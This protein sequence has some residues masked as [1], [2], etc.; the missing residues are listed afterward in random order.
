MAYTP[1]DNPYIPGDPYSYD[2]KWI[3]AKIKEAL[4]SIEGL[5]TGQSNLSNDFEALREY[6]YDYFD[7]LNISQEVEDKINE[8]YAA[9]FFDDIIEEWMNG[10]I[11]WTNPNLLD[12]PWFT[13][14][15]RGF[16]TGRAANQY[17]ADR[18]FSDANGTYTNSDSN[19]T[20][21]NSSAS[22]SDL[23]QRIIAPKMIGK[24]IVFSAK[25]NGTIYNTDP[26]TVNA[27]TSTNS[28]MIN[29]DCGQFSLI[30]VRG[31]SSF[32]F[33]FYVIIRT[34]TAQTITIEQA[35]LEAGPYSTLANDGAP[36]YEDELTKCQRYFIDVTST[37]FATTFAGIFNNNGDV[38]S[39]F[40]PLPVTM[41]T[42]PSLTLKASAIIRAS[43]VTTDYPITRSAISILGNTSLGLAVNVAQSGPTRSSGLFIINSGF[44]LSADL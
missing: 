34:K 29:K 8:L 14:N 40:I 23:I 38:F 32:V 7:N 11:K 17:V 36:N 20:V 9:G 1:T 35:K 42:T 13:V 25:V 15:Q 33:D 43:G 24:Q 27:K 28:T 19:I 22:N 6:V 41:Q 12:N 4:S 16:T 44:T 37:N 18:W 31:S 10:H 2:L 30:I 5:T 3:V 21:V 26:V 39:T